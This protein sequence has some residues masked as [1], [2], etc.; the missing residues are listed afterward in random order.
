MKPASLMEPTG[1]SRGAPA[2]S[3][4]PLSAAVLTTG[5]ELMLGKMT[6]TNSA[7]VSEFLTG[8]GLSVVRHVSVGDD[9]EALVEIVGDCLRRHEVTVVSGGLGPT[10]DDLTRMAVSR[11]LGTPLVFRSELAE[12]IGG[13]M[14]ERG[15]TFSDNNQRQAWLPE[16]CLLVPN[17]WGTAPSFCLDAPGRLM[18][19]VP[20][21]PQELK[22]IVRT[23]LPGKLAEKFPGR[24]GRHHT[25]VLR[26]G[27]LGESR[28]DLLLGDLLR[29]STNPVLGLLAGPYETR[30]LVTS[31]AD[32]E[33]GAR[34]LE[35]PVVARVRELLGPSYVGRDDETMVTESCKRLRS[36]GL[37]LGVL[38]TMTGGTAAEPFHRILGADGLAASLAA[39]PK[40]LGPGLRLLFDELDCDLVGVVSNP[41]DEEN[42]GDGGKKGAK[43][44]GRK[45]VKNGGK[46]MGGA[47]EKKKVARP[48]DADPELKQWRARLR[49]LRRDRKTGETLTVV[50][51]TRLIGNPTDLA[52]TRAG[53]LM[54]MRLWLFLK[55]GDQAGG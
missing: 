53:A 32:D 34:A 19:F 45:D 17:P 23:F 33:A 1:R 3:R 46:N 55:E 16:G 2:P 42:D 5:S 6:D 39:S 27:G 43:N 52:M 49:L 8:R 20:G 51:E 13:F 14:T 9:L 21:V 31:K 12:E 4:E 48:P 28:V 38:D 10:E 54:A 18:L 26:A 30:V 22:N 24:L 50:D 7:W 47:E 41:D 11:A 25:T 29:G 15:F 35:E 36:R 44:G 37:R 40:S